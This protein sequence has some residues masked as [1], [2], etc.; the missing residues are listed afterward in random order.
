MNYILGIDQGTSGTKA[1]VFDE[2]GKP[3][4]KGAETLK[5][6]YPENGH[7]E[8]DP[9]GILRNVLTAVA[10][11]LETFAS[12]GGRPDDIRACGISNQRETFVLWDRSGTPLCNAIVWQ[13]KRSVDICNRWRSAGYEPLIRERTGL[14]IDPYFSGS[15]LV[16]LYENIPA[17]RSKIDAGEACF[18]TIDT[19]L[20]YRLTN[21]HSFYTDYTNASRTLFFN[22]KELRWDRE[23][24]ELFGLGRLQLPGLG[25]SSGSFGGT[26]F[27][28]L[29]PSPLPITGV[30]GDSHAAAFGEGCFSPGEAK[31]TL[32]TGC[33]ILMNTGR[34][35]MDSRN[36]M[37]ST[38]CWSTADAVHYALE[39]VIVTCG[40][41]LEWLKN[42]LN[43]FTDSRQ[44]LEMANAVQDNGGVYL[45]PAFSG[46]GAPHW[47]MDRKAS[48][49][50]LTF[51][52]QKNHIVRAAL[53]SI[54]YQI[55]D[56]IVAM[57][58]NSSLDLSRLMVD[59]G[60]SANPFVTQFLAD[61]LEKE[62]VTIG[63]PDISALG[64]A[65]MSGLSAGI[66]PGIDY[67]CSLN[68]EKKIITP[69]PGSKAAK[70]YAG[71]L[72]TLSAGRCRQ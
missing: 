44:T 71:W 62:V 9:E 65:Y 11:C 50:G 72:E 2:H 1:L 70:Y 24:L 63:Q 30:I 36:G 16:W 4:A 15:K 67:L 26:D 49:T 46:L 3:V 5:T 28:G 56:V 58:E 6:S 41:T 48:I 37:V 39:G 45:I 17:V 51:G 57:E 59:G 31:A 40:A 64:A 42:E 68:T 52:T 13:C 33:S 35:C 29:L 12:G 43:L 47:E 22:L 60:I 61:L 69:A 10:Q 21:G 38:I 27:N 7:V 8:Q 54:P 20:L 34:T 25:P 18:G 32:G 66:Y 19:W 53:E 23:L 14:L 55:K